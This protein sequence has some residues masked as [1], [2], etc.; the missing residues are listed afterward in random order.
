MARDT[1]AVCR[2]CRREGEKLFLKGERCFSD[3]C[4]IERRPYAPGEQGNKRQKLSE[5]G[6]QL[7]EKQKVRQ[8]YGVSESQFKKYFEMADNKP[9]ITGENF[10][11]ILESRLDNIVYRLG[12]A[13]SRNEARQ[14]VRHGH[15][16]VNGERVDIP[17]Y[18]V[19]EGDEVE[20]KDS[21][22][23][24]KRMQEIVE[25]TGQQNI[26]AWVEANLENKTGKVLK[27]PEREDIDLPVREQLIVEF[28]SR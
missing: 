7:R 18:L 28:Y 24:M 10:L 2:K 21:S 22:K 13:A 4:A 15:F 11:K 6:V 19:E 9:G 3:K 5:F 26:P 27:E 12:F 23:D 17:S 25:F 20:V 1:K 8:I 14:L 16:L